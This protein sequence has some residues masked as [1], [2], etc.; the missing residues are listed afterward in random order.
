MASATVARHP[1][2]RVDQRSLALHRA[3][4][5]VLATSPEALDQARGRVGR[6]LEDG[7]VAREYAERWQR[8]LQL[9][10]EELAARLVDPGE[11][12]TALRQCS[13]FA[14]ALDPRTRWRIL[15]E[16]THPVRG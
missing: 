11:E 15:A 16:T 6:W 2:E 3:V 10:H 12:M 7:S 5:E 14:G 13:P 8:L 9:P 4:A 1:H